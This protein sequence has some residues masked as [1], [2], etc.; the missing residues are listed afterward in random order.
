[1]MK[2][3]IAGLKGKVK[4]WNV[5]RSKECKKIRVKFAVEQAMRA[6][7]GSKGVAFTVPL[8][9]SLYGGWMVSSTLRPL[10]SRESDRYPLYRRMCGSHSRSGRFRKISPQPKFYPRTLQSIASHYTDWA[11]W[12]WERKQS[13][14]TKRFRSFEK[15]LVFVR[16]LFCV[17]P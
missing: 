12:T 7:R 6:L 9:S 5:S 2:S 13:Y 4:G 1:M 14:I 3:C 11:M 15:T 17:M 16:I 8:T 10:Y